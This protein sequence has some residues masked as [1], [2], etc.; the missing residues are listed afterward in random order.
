[1]EEREVELHGAPTIE[2]PPLFRRDSFELIDIPP[3]EVARQLTLI[4]LIQ[5]FDIELNHHPEYDLFKRIQPKEC[6]KNWDK[7]ERPIHAPNLSNVTSRFN[8]V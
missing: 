3:L 6:L 1:M 5:S 7:S 2:L 8:Q 4:G